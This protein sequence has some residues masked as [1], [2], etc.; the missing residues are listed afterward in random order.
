MI[1][2]TS[3]RLV[4]DLNA[5]IAVRRFEQRLFAVQFEDAQIA[6]HRLRLAAAR[7]AGHVADGGHVD[8]DGAAGP[9]R[10]FRR[11]GR[12]AASTA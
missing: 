5:A 4:A 3:G 10:I 9:A 11:R 7:D 12:T 6:A 8:G 1:L 2:P